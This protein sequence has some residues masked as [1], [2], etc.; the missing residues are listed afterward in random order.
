MAEVD[1]LLSFR[2]KSNASWIIVSNEVGLG[3]VPPYP[4]GRIF[5]DALGR[6]NQRLTAAAT[7]SFFIMAGMPLP[8]K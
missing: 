4:L 6:A 3:L 7:E 2:K 5:R 8:L 1:A